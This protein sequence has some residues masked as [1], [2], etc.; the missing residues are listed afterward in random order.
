[1]RQQTGQQV[2]LNAEPAAIVPLGLRVLDV[3]PE[4][5]VQVARVEVVVQNPLPLLAVRLIQAGEEQIDGALEDFTDP[6]VVAAPA[7]QPRGIV[8][9]PPPVA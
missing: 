3:V 2:G 9:N 5:R 6:A 8:R 1:V 7:V 4:R